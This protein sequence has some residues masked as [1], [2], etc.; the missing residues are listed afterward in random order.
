MTAQ[1][2]ADRELFRGD[3]PY[4]SET[5]FR[6]SCVKGFARMRTSRGPAALSGGGHVGFGPGLI[7]S[8]LEREEPAVLLAVFEQRSVVAAGLLPGARDEL[9]QELA[10][11]FPAGGA[12]GPRSR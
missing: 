1:L 10:P 7:G 4:P 8:G 9:D 2:P 11:V 3:E 5:I 12:Y 6:N